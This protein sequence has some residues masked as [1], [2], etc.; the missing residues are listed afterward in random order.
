MIVA[1]AV[2]SKATG[3]I[4][5][6]GFCRQEDVPLQAFREDWGAMEGEGDESSHYVDTA[7]QE[8]KLKTPAEYTLSSS[9][10]LSDGQDSVTIS[11]L[12]ETS[13]VSWPDGV[14]T[15]VSDGLIEFSVDLPGSYVIK[16]E[17]VP[18]LAQ[19]ITIEAI[20]PA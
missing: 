20:A 13:L 18:Y 15:P 17:A 7:S 6:T 5:R 9:T 3:Q 2:Y 12:H 10:I 14:V 19:E 11:G 8:F 4:M 16:I 1:Y